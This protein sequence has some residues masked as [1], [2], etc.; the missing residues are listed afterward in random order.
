VH[1]DGTL[2]GHRLEYGYDDRTLF[3]DLSFTVVPGQALH[4]IGPNGSGK[5]TL[6]R[7]LCGLTRPDAGEVRWKGKDICD[8]RQEYLANL[9][10]VGHTNGVKSDISVR[11]NLRVARALATNHP[12]LSP[13]QALL[14]VGLEGYE[15]VLCRT[16]SAGQRRRVALARL[17]VNGAA[18]WLVDEPFT[19][20]DQDGMALVQALLKAH[21]GAG[22]SLVFTSH[23]LISL[24]GIQVATVCLE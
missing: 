20:I 24:D 17:H 4:I 3:S 9:A 19:G 22:G 10:Y 21:V 1:Y 16:L 14:R 8:V 2:E 11:A 6:L 18:L 7:I 5:T 23:H 15:D 13:E 12:V